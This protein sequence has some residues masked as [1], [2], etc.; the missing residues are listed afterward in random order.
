[1]KPIR[2][3]GYESYKTKENTRNN[4]KE[5]KD[6]AAGEDIEEDAP[7]F[8]VT[9]LNNFSHSNFANNELCVDSQKNHISNG[10]C[11]HSFANPKPSRRPSLITKKFCSANCLTMKNVL[12]RLWKLL[13]LII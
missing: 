10:L 7:F 1:M 6:I 13:H 11:A 8:L 12:I 2:D 5:T 4:K 3:P 9:Y